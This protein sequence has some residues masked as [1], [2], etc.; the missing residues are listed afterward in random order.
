[1]KKSIL[2]DAQQSVL[3]RIKDG[4]V[5]CKHCFTGRF[6]IRLTNGMSIKISISTVYSLK[7]L[8]IL[9]NDCR[10]IKNMQDEK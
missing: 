7:R 9:D 6:F 5:I 2:S 4:G 8:G 3:D 1:M 10:L